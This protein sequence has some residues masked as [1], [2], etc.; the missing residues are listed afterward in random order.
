MILP[1]SAISSEIA[2]PFL[3]DLEQDLGDTT[4]LGKKNP[5]VVMRLQAI[6]EA[7]GH[8]RMFDFREQDAMQS[9]LEHRQ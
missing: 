2:E 4:N 1:A 5:D 9:A 8:W 3:I 7:E 6:V